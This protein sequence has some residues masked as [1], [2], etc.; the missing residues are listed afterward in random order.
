MLNSA[1]LVTF[2]LLFVGLFIEVL[3]SVL[4]VLGMQT[5]FG[6]NLVLITLLGI[7]I[8]TAKIMVPIWLTIQTKVST[9][10]KVVLWTAVVILM[11]INAIGVYGQLTTF[12]R[13]VFSRVIKVNNEIADVE[14]R[15]K[16]I[17]VKIE[18]KQK[19]LD[20]FTKAMDVYIDKDYVTRGL[21]E[22]RKD[23]D[24][25]QSLIDEIEVLQNEQLELRKSLNNMLAQRGEI[26]GDFGAL[27]E[28]TSV[29]VDNPNEHLQLSY[30]LFIFMIMICFQPL[31]LMMV[32]SSVSELVDPTSETAKLR[33]KQKE[34]AAKRKLAEKDIQSKSKFLLQKQEELELKERI[35]EDKV[36][37]ME[38]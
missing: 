15:I 7:G 37:R 32:R 35:L 2:I 20:Q 27:R 4:A 17:D 1:I 16:L 34:I 38:D 28:L 11:H 24:E 31:G 3:A 22:R 25:R 8:E 23:Q 6:G 30:L 18:P 9:I 10:R 13:D 36:H 19:T 33:K 21:R 14:E 5:I 12:S 26:E 29:F